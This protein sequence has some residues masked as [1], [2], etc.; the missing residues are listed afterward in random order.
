MQVDAKNDFKSVTDLEQMIVAN[1]LN[2]LNI[3]KSF[4]SPEV[5]AATAA[6]SQ[7]YENDEDVKKLRD[8]IQKARDEEDIDYFFFHQNDEWDSSEYEKVKNL[9]QDTDIA[10][11]RKIIGGWLDANTYAI[12][13][14]LAHVVKIDSVKIVEFGG[15]EGE[16]E[17]YYTTVAFT[18]E[19]ATVFVCFNGWY[20]SYAGAEFNEAFFVKPVFEITQNFVNIK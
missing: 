20:Q 10:E 9:A 17:A 7:I 5:S 13:Q 4:V 2:A 18:R 16:G 8:D 14:H 1:P 6:M 15:G 12:Y 3:L 19:N 11:A